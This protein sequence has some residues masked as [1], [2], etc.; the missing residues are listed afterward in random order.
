MNSS[1]K[2]RRGGDPVEIYAIRGGDAVKLGGARGVE[3]RRA[4]SVHS[5]SSSG[6]DAA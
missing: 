2:D 1:Q 5:P 4:P 3:A 6:I